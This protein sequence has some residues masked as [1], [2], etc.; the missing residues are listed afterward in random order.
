MDTSKIIF[1]AET[2]RKCRDMRFS[3][4]GGHG[5]ESYS[6]TANSLNYLPRAKAEKIA[7]LLNEAIAPI[8]IDLEADLRAELVLSGEEL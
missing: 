4:D 8:L 3:I 2:L 5:S 1:L 7:A 6:V